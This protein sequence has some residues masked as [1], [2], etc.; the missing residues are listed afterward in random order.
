[1]SLALEKLL[2]P[3]N[4]HSSGPEV[5]DTNGRLDVSVVYTSDEATIA[6]LKRAGALAGRLDAQITLVVPQ[7][8]P[9][10]LPLVSPPVLLD[11]SEKRFRG[12][13][14]ATSV[15]TR[16]CLYLCRD[17]VVTLCEVLSPDA[18][19]VLGG[20]KRWWPTA[21]RK[22]ARQLRRAGFEVIYTEME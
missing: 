18:V 6:A 12:T 22:L 20:R 4:G 21:E 17:R 14:A 11:F 19:V 1:M 2:T 3:R 13:A 8:V 9:F 10:P 15:E 5:A 16:V 7:I